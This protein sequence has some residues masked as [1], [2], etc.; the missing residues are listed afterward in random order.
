MTSY[1]F[2]RLLLTVPT[3]VGAYAF[4]FLLTRMVPGDPALIII[5]ENFTQQSYELVRQKLGLDLPVWQQ[6]WTS[7]VNAVQGDFG[8]SFRNGRSVVQN[9]REQFPHT[10]QLGAAALFVSVI[11]GVPLGVMAATHRNRL[12][13]QLAMVGALLALCAPNFWLGVVFIVVFSLHLGWF[14]AFGVGFSDSP[15]VILNHLVLPAVVLGLSGAGVLARVSRSSM[16]EVLSQ[17]YVRTARATGFHQ[18]TVVYR[19]ALRNALVTI[20]TIIGLEAIKHITGTVVIE[21]VFARPGMGRALVDSILARDYPQIQVIL[22]FFIT[23]SILI[24]L[25]I[26]LSYV[27]ISPRTRYD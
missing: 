8:E 27:L 3:L 14:P 2:K 23:L 4:I 17:D 22:L 19:Y 6:L 16:L 20:V 21:V 13:D 25:L 15:A 11:V 26:D 18:R 5:E 1:I 12:P 7:V 9:L 24:N 10:L